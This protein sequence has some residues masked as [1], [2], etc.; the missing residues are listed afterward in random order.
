MIQAPEIKLRSDSSDDGADDSYDVTQK[1]WI[2]NNFIHTNG[3]ECVE[4]KEASKLNLIEDNICQSQKDEKSG[5]FGS[6]GSDNTFRNN[7]ISNCVGSGFRVGGDGPDGEYGF[8]NN[9]YDNTISNARASAFNLMDWP[10]GTMCGNKISDV[11]EVVSFCFVL[12]SH[13]PCS[14]QVPGACITKGALKHIVS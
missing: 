6:R 1:N 7:D 3:N 8:D 11:G 13:V 14:Q 10:Q 4:C 12:K 2:H 9:M 5:C